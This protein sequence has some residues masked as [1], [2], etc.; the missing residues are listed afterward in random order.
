VSAA[1]VCGEDVPKRRCKGCKS[2]KNR[3]T[4]ERRKERDGAYWRKPVDRRRARPLT[5]GER[6][7]M[8][9]ALADVAL[10]EQERDEVIRDLV[11]RGVGPLAMAEGMGV[12]RDVA[13]RW[14]RRARLARV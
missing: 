5:E 6:H 9:D 3:R 10:A 2:E 4:Y 11:A 8:E 1:H 13:G 12:S 7:D 14:I